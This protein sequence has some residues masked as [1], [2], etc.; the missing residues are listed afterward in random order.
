MYDRT[1]CTCGNTAKCSYCG[2]RIA[3][4]V[5][6]EGRPPAQRCGVAEARTRPPAPEVRR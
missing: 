4:V 2:P 3:A 1:Q 5:R 6:A